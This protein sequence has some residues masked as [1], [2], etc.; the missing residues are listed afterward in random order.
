[1][2]TLVL[3]LTLILGVGF[4]GCTKQEATKKAETTV[5]TPDG[6]TKVTT[7]TKVEASGK[8]PPPA[9]APGNP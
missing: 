4:T 7:E 3:A 1:M 8:N 5:T 2:K 9:T 6:E